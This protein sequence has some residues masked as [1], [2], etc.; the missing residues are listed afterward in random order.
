M[1]EDKDRIFLFFS[2][3]LVFVF[4]LNSIALNIYLF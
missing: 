4:V 3:K 1:L 2:P